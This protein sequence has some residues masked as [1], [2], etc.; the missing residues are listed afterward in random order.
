MKLFDVTLRLSWIA[1]AVV[2]TTGT[3][4]IVK[5]L[6]ATMKKWEIEAPVHFVGF[7]KYNDI[8]TILH[9]NYF[10]TP[11]NLHGVKTVPSLTSRNFLNFYNF[12]VFYPS[13][14][15]C[16]DVYHVVNKC[17]NYC[18]YIFVVPGDDWMT[19]CDNLRALDRLRFKIYVTKTGQN[20]HRTVDQVGSMGHY[21]DLKKNELRNRHLHVAA[22]GV[23]PFSVKTKDLGISVEPIK[24][25][26][27]LFNFTYDLQFYVP[28]YLKYPN[29]TWGGFMAD[30]VNGSTDFAFLCVSSGGSIDRYKSIEYTTFGLAVN[31]IF[32]V[33]QP[34][35]R[36]DWTAFVDPFDGT[37]W[38]VLLALILVLVAV[39]HFQFVSLEMFQPFTAAF[40]TIL[41]PLVNQSRKVHKSTRKLL[42]VW[43]FGNLV[44]G[45]YYGSNLRSYITYPS[46]ESIPRTFSGLSL[47]ADYKTLMIHAVGSSFNT[48]MAQSPVPAI[49]KIR[50]RYELTRDL[51]QCVIRAGTES[52]VACIGTSAVFPPVINRHLKLRRNFDPVVNSRGS[53]LRIFMHSVLQKDSKYTE[54]VNFIT[55]WSR[56]TGLVEKWM[57]NVLEYFSTLSKPWLDSDGREVKAKLVAKAKSL[58]VG[59]VQAFGL[60]HLYVPFGVLGMGGVIAGV[61]FLFERTE[62]AGFFRLLRR[63]NVLTVRPRLLG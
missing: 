38:M 18:L 12:V 28:K 62:A 30:I 9:L 48:F 31:L 16:S 4:V 55:G 42:I 36:L 20:L 37:V 6:R 11:F 10:Y 53:V 58:A 19:K 29:G 23:A 2:D 26:A 57:G 32:I 52:K 45:T 22:S 1:L 5:I 43:I 25:A 59:Q 46:V 44:I 13:S 51:S 56:D 41:A 17:N 50:D 49:R 54:A 27:E 40:L 35:V 39:L 60:Q 34:L 8:S 21:F 14:R 61:G 7:P 24:I 15:D 63:V 3:D 33:G 47:R